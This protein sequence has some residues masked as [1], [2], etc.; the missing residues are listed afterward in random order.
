MTG[1]AMTSTSSAKDKSSGGDPIPPKCAVIEVVSRFG[2]YAKPSPATT[3]PI[4]PWKRVPL[5]NPLRHRPEFA[6]P[7]GFRRYQTHRDNR[8]TI[9]LTSRISRL[10]AIRP[11]TVAG[12]RAIGGLLYLS[13]TLRIESSPIT[14]FGG[15]FS[16]FWLSFCDSG[17]RFVLLPVRAQSES[18][19]Q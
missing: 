3:V 17:A 15:F 16:E 7:C 4:W 14:V 19:L 9:L 6:S 18:C 13:R 8:S 5:F 1:H 12:N 2:N 11:S 10:S